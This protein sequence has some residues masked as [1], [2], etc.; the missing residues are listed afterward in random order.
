MPAVFQGGKEK[1]TMFCFDCKAVFAVVLEPDY[2]EEMIG[3][4]GQ[5]EDREV[6]YCPFC[7]SDEIDENN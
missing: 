3:K 2:P 6:G 1:K 4:D 5:V 7:G